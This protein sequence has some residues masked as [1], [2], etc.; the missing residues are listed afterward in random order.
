[1]P[2]E[3]AP[4]GRWKCV[5]ML[6][7]SIKG[8]QLAG[9]LSQ[10]WLCNASLAVRQDFKIS[11]C[12]LAQEAEL[13]TACGRAIPYAGAKCTC[14]ELRSCG[15]AYAPWGHRGRACGSDLGARV[16]AKQAA[17]RLQLSA[18][19]PACLRL[20]VLEAMRAGLR[21]GPGGS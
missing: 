18:S 2:R 15:L 12:E 10:F 20:Q 1:M 16:C 3:T 5:C 14:G 7:C 8:S 17:C 21:K 13:G 9:E 19:P 11:K 4:L 6:K